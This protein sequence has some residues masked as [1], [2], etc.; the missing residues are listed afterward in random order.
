MWVLGG[1]GLA[2]F[3]L[4]KQRPDGISYGDGAFAGVLSGVFG[5]VVAT[6]VS[7][8]VRLIA[9]RIFES[10]QSALEDALSQ[11]PEL[12]GPFRELLLRMASPEIS[13]LTIG[14]TFF[15]NLVLYSLFAMIGGILTVAVI[16]RNRTGME[17]K[18]QQS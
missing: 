15:L 6:V 1:G 11:M 2:A 14:F 17:T 13:A 10:Q 4:T 18:N 16:N 12:E 8:P 5:A 9:S 7:I 3:M